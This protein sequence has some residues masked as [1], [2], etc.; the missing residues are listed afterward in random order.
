MDKKMRS[1][2]RRPV[3]KAETLLKKAEKATTKLADYDEKKRDPII[4]RYKKL[5]KEGKVK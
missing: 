1:Q 3:R 4:D 2:I 5:K